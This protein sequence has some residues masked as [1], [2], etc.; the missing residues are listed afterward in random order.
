MIIGENLR[1]RAL[2]RKDLP[3]FTEWLNDPEVTENLLVSHPF[4][5]ESEEQWYEGV[6][7]SSIYE[8]PL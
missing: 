2:D 5:L 1:L 3:M 6:L 4:S 8:R 7:K